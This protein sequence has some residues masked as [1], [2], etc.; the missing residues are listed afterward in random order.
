MKTWAQEVALLYFVASGRLKQE[1][2]QRK[3]S[4]KKAGPVLPASTRL[5]SIPPRQL[6]LSKAT[7]AKTSDFSVVFGRNVAVHNSAFSQQRDVRARAL[8]MSFM[9]EWDSQKTLS[10]F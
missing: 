4:D 7:L 10:D 6:K 1:W 2:K 9:S 3:D 8:H 5:L